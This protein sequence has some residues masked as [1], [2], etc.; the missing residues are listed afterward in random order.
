MILLQGAALAT[1]L[2][3]YVLGYLRSKDPQVQIRF[4]GLVTFSNGESYLPVIPQ[5]PTGV[6][7]N[8]TKVLSVAP[9]GMEYPDLIEFDNHLF[10]IHMVATSTGKLTLPRMSEYPILLKEGLLPQ[11]LLLP[12]NLFIPAE[13]KVIL[14]ALPYNPQALS[15][16]DTQNAKNTPKTPV[17][18]R[19]PKTVYLSSL[20]TQALVGVDP[21]LGTV[22]AKIPLNCVPSSLVHS[23]DDKLV[24]ATCLTT[25]EL[26]VIDTQANLIKTR[27]PVGAKPG[28]V[29]LIEETGDII[30]S[31][32]Y[33]SYL[34]FIDMTS[35]VAGE[36]LALPSGASVM[37]YSPGAKSVYVAGNSVRQPNGKM[38]GRIFEVDLTTR[39]VTRT[40]TTMPNV[41][42]LW[43]ADET[44]QLWV[45]SR[46]QEKLEVLDLQT[47]K[48]LKTLDVGEKPVAFAVS[49]NRLY[50]V[51]ANAD[52][53]DVFD[54]KTQTPLPPISLAAGSF[55]SGIAISAD[56]KLAYISGAAT[57]SLYLVDLSAN[58]MFKSLP[59]EVRGIAITVIGGEKPVSPPRVVVPRKPP[60]AQK[61]D[62]SAETG[63][64]K[65]TQGSITAPK[66]KFSFWGAGKRESVEKT[67]D[68]SG[69]HT[70]KTVQ[71]EAPVNAG[72]DV[73]PEKFSGRKKAKDDL[74]PLPAM[75]ENVN[76][77]P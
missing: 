77:D 59:L 46:T 74:K 49:G 31:N 64:E 25:D 66:K 37:T 48:T 71:K 34:N 18:K 22:Q 73:K 5:D 53:L 1:E 21:D 51:A 12:A 69:T 7:I 50:V 13:L 75:E 57:D 8:A 30:V 76:L 28:D 72:P 41:S 15:E 9:Q 55:P 26:I 44:Q 43:V 63:P 39:K 67:E 56:G 29:L 10:L 60:L 58:H 11:D 70:Q 52:R 62:A 68:L 65:D 42:A 23:S 17:F 33:S 24:F 19:I 61:P 4:D 27:I 38:A 35:L 2:P 14:G 20:A 6:V 36:T 54:W 40:L 47:G 3:P 16:S 45:A 32:R